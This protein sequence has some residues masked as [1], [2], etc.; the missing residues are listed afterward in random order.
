[1][2]HNCTVPESPQETV[3]DGP[4]EPPTKEPIAGGAGER[5]HTRLAAAEL[6]I[7]NVLEGLLIQICTWVGPEIGSSGGH[8]AKA[9]LRAIKKSKMPVSKCLL[10]GRNL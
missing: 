4:V 2:A 3:T 1:M 7:E 9:A 5:L 10:M 6:G 8:W